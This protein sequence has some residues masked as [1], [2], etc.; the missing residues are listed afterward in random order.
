MEKQSRQKFFKILFK[1]WKNVFLNTQ[2]LMSQG[3]KELPYCSFKSN[4]QM[5]NLT[6]SPMVIKMVISA[7]D[8]SSGADGISVVVFE[9][10]EAEFTYMLANLF[11]LCLKES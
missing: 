2:I 3:K 10:C 5:D 4:M 11:N 1:L 8:S 9:N 7:L 6:A